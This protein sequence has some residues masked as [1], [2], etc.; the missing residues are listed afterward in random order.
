MCEKGGDRRFVGR[1]SLKGRE[2]AVDN[3]TTVSK[4]TRGKT[5]DRRGGAERI[6]MGFSE[7]MDTIL[8]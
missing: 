3:Q 5:S 4:A 6:I 8:N 7:R 1:S 2:R